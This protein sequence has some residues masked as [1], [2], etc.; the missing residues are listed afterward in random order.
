MVKSNANDRNKLSP[1][2]SARL[3]EL[4]PQ[5]KVRV[6]VLLQVDE[7]ENAA[8]KRLSRTERKA[9]MSALQKS[10]TKAFGDIGGIIKQFDGQPLAEK[11]NLLGAIPVEITVAGVDALTHSDSVKA[12][13]EDQAINN[14]LSKPLAL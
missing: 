12:V 13:I 6:I 8:T 10:A 2:F 5:N 7:A 1:G 4:G 9:A 11:P 3:D 14:N